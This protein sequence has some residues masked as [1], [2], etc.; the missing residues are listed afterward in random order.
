MRPAL[1][2]LSLRLMTSRG[3]LSRSPWTSVP[4]CHGLPSPPRPLRWWAHG[5]RVSNERRQVRQMFCWSGDGAP[6]PK[7][8]GGAAT[9]P[10]RKMP[11]PGLR[12]FL[13]VGGYKDSAPDGACRRSAS[14]RPAAAAPIR[15]RSDEA[16]TGKWLNVRRLIEPCS[17]R[18]RSSPRRRA[19]HSSRR[20]RCEG[21]NPGLLDLKPVGIWLAGISRR[22]RNNSN[23]VAAFSPR[24]PRF[25][26]ATLG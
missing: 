23:G 20:S 11:P 26:G 18:W 5:L 14:L 8:K 24:L 7:S 13:G 1:G 2:S 12:N 25:V 15:T 3:R 10:Y 6:S 16:G 21:G 19:P 4:M 9:P 22:Q 17:D